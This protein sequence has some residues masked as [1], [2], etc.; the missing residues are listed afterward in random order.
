LIVESK[1]PDGTPVLIWPS[2]PGDREA[3]V[4]VNRLDVVV[5]LGS[6]LPDDPSGT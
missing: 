5:D 2:L 4:A 3:L 1:L 6:G